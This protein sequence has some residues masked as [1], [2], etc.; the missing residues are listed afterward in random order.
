VTFFRTIFKPEE[1]ITG[2]RVVR[3]DLDENSHFVDLRTVVRRAFMS[4]CFE[5]GFER[6]YYICDTM[7][8]SDMFLRLRN[9]EPC[10]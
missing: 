4:S 1:S 2:Q 7:K 9:I 8:C 10:I 6:D 5:V 3:E